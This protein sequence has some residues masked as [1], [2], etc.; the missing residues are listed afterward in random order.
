MPPYA[1]ENKRLSYVMRSRK[2]MRTRRRKK[3]RWR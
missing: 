1:N 2:K 3:R